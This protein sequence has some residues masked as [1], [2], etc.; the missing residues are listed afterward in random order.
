MTSTIPLRKITIPARQDHAGMDSMT[1]AVPWACLQCGA[2]RG[3]PVMAVSYDGSRQL[4][5]HGWLNPCGHIETY[6]EVREAWLARTTEENAERFMYLRDKA[7]FVEAMRHTF[8]LSAS[9]DADDVELLLD[10][11]RGAIVL[12]ENIVQRGDSFLAPCVRCEALTPIECDPL[13]FDPTF[14]YCGG[15][16]RCCP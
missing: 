3:E 15:S 1:I 4:P 10:L 14:H 5:A 11:E 9:F 8:G 2:P 16:P 6:S 12:D 7:W 13:D